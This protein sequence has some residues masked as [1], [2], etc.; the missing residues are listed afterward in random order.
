[1]TKVG[2]K[3]AIEQHSQGINGGLRQFKLQWIA[4]EPRWASREGRY[5][6]AIEVLSDAAKECAHTVHVLVRAATTSEQLLRLVDDAVDEQ[7]RNMATATVALSARLEPVPG[8]APA[9]VDR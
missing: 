4:V 7:L 3:A 5:L 2:I 9:S 1:M 8:H 6:V